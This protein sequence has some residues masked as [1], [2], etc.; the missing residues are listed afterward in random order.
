MK[1]LEVLKLVREENMSKERLEAYYT[2]LSGLFS[3]LQIELAEL[4]KQEALFMGAPRETELSVA[5]R[6]VLWRAGELGQRLIMLKRY[7]LATNTQLR[8][9]KTR[10]YA[11][12]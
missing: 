6:K 8:S 12:L 4:E 10:I 7:A 9:I 11:L 1:L 3:D 5:Q 2:S